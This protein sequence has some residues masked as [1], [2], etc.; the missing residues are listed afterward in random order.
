MVECVRQGRHRYF[1]IASQE[2]AQVLE[3]IMGLVAKEPGLQSKTPARMRFARTC[4]DHM[5]GALAVKLHDRII[6]LKWL[7]ADSS[8]VTELGRTELRHVGIDLAPS[9][10]RRRFAHACLD[11]S[12]RK[13]HFGGQLGAAILATFETKR[14]VLRQPDSRELVL[15]TKGSNALNNHFGLHQ[16]PGWKEPEI[17]SVSKFSR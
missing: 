13:T 5:A 17:D 4:Y 12:E 9:T 2:V 14:W 8:S 6:A 16:F 3:S 7:T 11:W 1:R 15:T 10:S